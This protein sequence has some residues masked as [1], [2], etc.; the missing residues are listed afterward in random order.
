MPCLRLASIVFAGSLLSACSLYLA[1][2]L[3]AGSPEQLASGVASLRPGPEDGLLIGA[4]D[5]ARCSQSANA[6]ATGALIRTVL[7]SFPD[8]RVF[9]AG[10]NAYEDGS[11]SQFAQCYEPT[12][13]SFN[14]RTAPAPGNHD[15]HTANAAA[16]FQYFDYYRTDPE[17][18]R[19]GYYSFDIKGWHV[20]SLN[21]NVPMNAASPQVSW[22]AKDLQKTT[23]RCI[24][25]VWHHPLFS[26]GLHGSEDYDPGRRTGVLWETLS[27]YGADVIVNGHDH[28]YERFARQDQNAV[29]SAAGIRQFVVGTG[30]AK[31]RALNPPKPNSE[32]RDNEHY[33]VL[34]LTLHPGSYEWTFLGADGVAYDRSDAAVPCHE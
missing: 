33:G 14:D 11:Q 29:A 16:Y 12:W 20:V 19:R 23:K 21:S 18:G 17:A 9:T 3:R 15:Y 28:N 8:A 27:R 6:A 13:G 34:A 4:G 30:G 5:I 26:S 25:A 32:V 10:D 2:P 22:L 7:K 24:L 31:L 1:P